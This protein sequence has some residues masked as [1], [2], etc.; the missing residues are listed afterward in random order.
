MI[1][2][3]NDKSLSYYDRLKKFGFAICLALP[4]KVQCW[5]MF[6]LTTLETRRFRGD[7]IEAYKL[8]KGYGN[9]YFNVFFQLSSTHLRGHELK[10]YKPRSQLDVRKY[11]FQLGLLMNGIVYLGQ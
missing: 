5:T 10:I 11:F 4:Y 7:L 1:D 6:C 2:F 3:P 9:A 8:F